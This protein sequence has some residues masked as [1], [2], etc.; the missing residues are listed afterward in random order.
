[1]RKNRLINLVVVAMLTLS[2]GYSY[3]NPS[4]ATVVR[5]TVTFTHPN[6]NS[7]NITNTPGSIINWQH[8][9]IG[10]N[11]VTRFIQQSSR[12]AV[13]NRI[14]GQNP[15]KILG[16]LTS[17]GRVFL[18]NPNGVIFGR[19]SVIDTAGLITSTLNISDNDFHQWQNALRRFCQ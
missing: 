7:L 2:G 17:N 10:A 5:G 8:F 3:A 1:M 6:A 19:N 11:E 16:S 18:I 14:T 4:G 15:S 13:L 9:G 12:S